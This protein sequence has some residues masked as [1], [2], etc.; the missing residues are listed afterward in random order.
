[1][2]LYEISNKVPT[3]PQGLFM[4]KERVSKVNAS[5]FFLSLSLFPSLHQEGSV[6][7]E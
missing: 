4:S 6:T 2:C 7:T 3:S 5:F 1:M